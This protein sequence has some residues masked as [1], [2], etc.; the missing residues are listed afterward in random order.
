MFSWKCRCYKVKSHIFMIAN[1]GIILSPPNSWSKYKFRYLHYMMTYESFL[2]YNFSP[3]A[4]FWVSTLTPCFV[5]T[6]EDYLCSLLWHRYWVV[7][8]WNLETRP[9]PVQHQR[10]LSRFQLPFIS[11]WRCFA[12]SHELSYPTSSPQLPPAFLSA[13]LWC[14]LG[15]CSCIL[16]GMET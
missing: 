2:L 5:Q 8:T 12:I 11:S 7:S 13:L 6:E 3:D 16:L 15:A 9:G 1:F 10:Q 14:L 4:A